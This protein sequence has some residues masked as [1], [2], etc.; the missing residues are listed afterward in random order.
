MFIHSATTAKQEEIFVGYIA[1]ILVYENV[2]VYYVN[3]LWFMWRTL[4]EEER[5]FTTVL[6]FYKGILF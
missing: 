6:E 4:K 3:V 1:Q 5:D 2:N